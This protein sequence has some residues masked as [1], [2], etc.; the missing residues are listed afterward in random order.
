MPRTATSGLCFLVLATAPAPAL[1]ARFD[2]K[3][4]PP[5]LIPPR[6]KKGRRHDQ[7]AQARQLSVQTIQAKCPGVDS[8]AQLTFAL[9]LGPRTVATRV[10]QPRPHLSILMVIR[11]RG[12]SLL[13]FLLLLTSGA[14]SQPDAECHLSVG[15][16]KYDFSAL[17]GDKS[18]SRTRSSPPTT[19]TD[20]LRFNICKE[21]SPI[22]GVGSGDQV[23]VRRNPPITF[24]AK[25]VQCPSGTWACLSKTNIKQGKSDRVVAVIPLAH[26]PE[27][28]AEYTVLSCAFIDAILLE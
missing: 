6:E 25:F 5:F 24:P 19:M 15:D 9:A 14:S 21:L 1:P 17:K 12:T 22:E 18:I 8:T 26:E 23:R 3:D 2:I 4:S 27:L 10:S 16:Y 13:W 7:S 11:Q 20:T 28:R